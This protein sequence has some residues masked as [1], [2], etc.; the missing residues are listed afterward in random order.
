L[1]VDDDPGLRAVLCDL[2]GVKGFAPLAVESGQAALDQVGQAGYAVAL[3]DLRLE[4]MPGL[5]VV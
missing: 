4:N 2:L 5:E 3:V 1:I